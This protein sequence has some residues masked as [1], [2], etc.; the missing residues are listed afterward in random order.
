[1]CRGSCGQP[2]SPGSRRW[3]R[4]LTAYGPR[5]AELGMPPSSAMADAPVK[6]SLALS[7][8]TKTQV[9]VHYQETLY[10]AVTC[11]N[12]EEKDLERFTPTI[13]TARRD[14]VTV[15]ALPRLPPT[16]VQS[17]GFRR[18]CGQVG[19][20]VGRQ[21]L[22]RDFAAPYHPGLRGSFVCQ[23][24]WASHTDR[25]VGVRAGNSGRPRSVRQ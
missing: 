8:M 20:A 17:Y 24:C 14:C 7:T 11:G 1:M 5:F 18:A 15:S 6:L 10:L 23:Q 2:V 12:S 3:S 4:M 16:S 19:H 21:R 9:R 13:S 22:H 25:R